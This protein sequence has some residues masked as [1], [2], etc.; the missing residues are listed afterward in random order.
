MP[1]LVPA[2][3]RTQVASFEAGSRVAEAFLSASEYEA[4]PRPSPG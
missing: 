2:K 4:G 3:A 1:P